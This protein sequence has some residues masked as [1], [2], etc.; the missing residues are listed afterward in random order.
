MK[1]LLAV[2]LTILTLAAGYAAAPKRTSKTVRQER[3]ATSKKIDNTKRQIQTNIEDTR[4]EL[5]RLTLLQGQ[6]SEQNA[7]IAAMKRSADSVSRVSRLMADSVAATEARVE[8]LR[9]SYASA[10]RTIRSQRQTTSTTAFIFSSS[11]VSEAYRRI[12]YLRE[13]GKWQTE[14]AR[15]LRSEAAKL[16][17]AKERLD[18]ARARLDVTIRSMESERVKLQENVTMASDL[19]ASLKRQGSNLNKVLAQ[20]Q[21]Q[22]RKLDRELDRII[23]EEMR[24]AAQEEEAK[25]KAAEEARA[26]QQ[27]AERRA[28]E[29]KKNEEKSK[30]DK[31][32][33]KKKEKKKDK[34]GS[35][36]DKPAETPAAKPTDPSAKP[37]P[38][39][40]AKPAGNFADQ[41][42]KLPSPVDV[43]ATVTGTFGRHTHSEF[44]KVEL[45]N[46]GIDFEAPSGASARAVF[47]GVVSMIIVMDGYQNVVLVRHGEYLTV[48]AGI[49]ELSVR[50][51][52]EVA[53]GQILGRLYSDPADG[54]R[55]RLH[56]EVRHEKEKL[57][58]ADWLR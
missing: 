40:A 51:G 54:Y 43:A 31:K 16:E 35:T 24:K 3:A 27:E 6:I 39:P 4:R 20:Q 36:K 42:G 7:R 14:K 32:D 49:E 13:L 5:N 11:S 22:A 34:K 26:Q 21:E 29:E 15:A 33:N 8:T 50:K 10:L 12:R 30:K 46:N 56:F 47:P 9:G 45:V 1:R 41:K 48:Y 37:Q 57:N 25:R 52:Q 2:V 55:T 17:A 38:Q 44:S 58:P 23:E 19:V 53:A 18:S 28:A